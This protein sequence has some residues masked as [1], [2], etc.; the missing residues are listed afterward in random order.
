MKKLL[1]LL[2]VFSLCFSIQ[3]NAVNSN[4]SVGDNLTEYSCS[5]FQDDNISVSGDAYFGRC[6]Q[7]TCDGRKWN[8]SYYSTK[9]VSCSNGNINPYIKVTKSGCSAYQNKT[10][11]GNLVKYCTTISYYDC[12]RVSNGSNYVTT[13]KTTK[14]PTTQKPV[15]KPT[16][17]QPT[18][19][20]PITE[21]PK[22]NNTY[23]KSITLSSGTI[24]FNRDVKEYSIQVDS[25]ITSISVQALPESSTSTVNVQGNTSLI[26]GNNVITITVTAQDGSS[27]NYIIN[28]T[29]SSQKSNNANLESLTIEGYKI[30]FNSNVYNYNITF[31]GEESLEIMAKTVD[32]NAI[33][34]I[35][36]NSNLKNNSVIKVI[37]TAEDNTTT[38]TYNITVKK[39]GNG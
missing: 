39:K 25:G 11:T 27:T 4:A 28:V 13:T 7:A 21:A 36:G 8:M 15:T 26:E 2:V 29:K 16:T 19:E 24:D 38:Q 1:Y 5:A 35:E 17:A 18:T 34:M 22:D 32:A 3:V 33:Y 6:M 10:C 23:L 14:K 30:N 12:N 31:K 9:S 20:L 37:V